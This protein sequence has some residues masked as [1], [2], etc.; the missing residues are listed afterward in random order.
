MRSRFPT[1]PPTQEPTLL[2][3]ESL[4]CLEPD[5][6]GSPKRGDGTSATPYRVVLVMKDEIRPTRPT[7]IKEPTKLPTWGPLLSLEWRS[8]T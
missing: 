1:P 8:A 7:K 4:L 2:N 5:V 6:A 3:L